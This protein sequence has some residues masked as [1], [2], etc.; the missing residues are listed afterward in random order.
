MT[1]SKLQGLPV[2]GY[3]PQSATKVEIVNQNKLRE[4]KLLR[5]VEAL[6]DLGTADPFWASVAAQHFQEGFMALNRA[7]FQ[8]ARIKL[9][10]DPE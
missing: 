5:L 6:T 2:A 4:E 9:D 10:G 1:D 7:V 8:P 3:L